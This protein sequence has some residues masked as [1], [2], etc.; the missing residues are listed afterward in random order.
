MQVYKFISRERYLNEAGYYDEMLIPEVAVR[1]NS[2]IM[3]LMD[4]HGS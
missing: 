3:E 4:G 1:P 2:I